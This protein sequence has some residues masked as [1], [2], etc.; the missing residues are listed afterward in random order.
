MLRAPRTPPRSALCS[1]TRLRSRSRPR[2]PPAGTRSSPSN[3]SS[4]GGCGSDGLVDWGCESFKT[5][6]QYQRQPTM[7]NCKFSLTAPSVPAPP[8]RLANMAH[9]T[10]RQHVH[11]VVLGPHMTTSSQVHP[12]SL[13]P[14]PSRCCSPACRAGACPRRR[15]SPDRARGGAGPRP[16]PGRAAPSASG[17]AAPS[18]SGG[19]A[20]SVSVGAA[21][22]ASGH[23]HTHTHSK[24]PVLGIYATR[25]LLAYEAMQQ[26]FYVTGTGLYR[27]EPEYSFLW[28]FS[29]ALARHGQP[30]A[31]RRRAPQARGRAARAYLRPAAVS[32]AGPRARRSRLAGHRSR[33]ARGSRRRVI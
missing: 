31:H 13:A 32:R 29:Q 16:P 18:A 14:W 17:G 26:N 6:R 3:S 5:A 25:A 4:S 28:P 24:Q 1:T 10:P 23:A 21:S 12:R 30:L 22:F 19:A 33:A 7:A 8:S 15:R 2:R 9:R 20:P 11:I 27:G